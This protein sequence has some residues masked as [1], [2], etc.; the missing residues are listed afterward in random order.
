MGTL[1]K[2]SVLALVLVLM[3]SV[4]PLASGAKPVGNL[5]WL[6][7]SPG[8]SGSGGDQDSARPSISADGRYITFWS[9]ATD[10][11][12]GMVIDTG[13][14]GCGCEGACGCE[15]ECDCELEISNVYLYDVATGETTLVTKGSAGVGC[16][17]A[18]DSPEIS[19]DGS[20]I[21]FRSNATDLIPGE[22]T[23]IDD[24]VFLYDV[25]TQVTTLITPGELGNGLS[26]GGVWGNTI[27]ADGS[28]VAF[29]TSANDVIP[30]KTLNSKYNVFYYDDNTGMTTLVTKGAG[31]LGGDY[32]SVI[33]AISADGTK[34]AFQSRATDLIPSMT[35]THYIN[36]FL[37]D[38]ATEDITLITKGPLGNGCD[39]DGSTGIMNASAISA[40]NTTVVFQSW[41]TDLFDDAALNGNGNIFAYDVATE[42]ITLITAGPLGVGGSRDSHG[43]NISA[44]GSTIG[45][46]SRATDLIADVTTT[47]QQVFTYDV[48]TGTT[49]LVTLGS[50][51]IGGN[52]N[53]NRPSLNADGSLLTF[54]SDATDLMDAGATQLRQVFLVHRGIEFNVTFDAQNDTKPLVVTVAEGSP[55]AQPTD[56]TKAGYVFAGWWTDPTGGVLWDF[57]T[58]I[59]A[60]MTL[61]AHWT[62]AVPPGPD[63]PATGDSALLLS[64][65]IA[66]GFGWIVLMVE[67]KKRR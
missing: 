38:A 5:S 55:V 10:L 51:G 57:S 37:Y 17:G 64:P 36:S 52:A 26:G 34:I 13:S 42:V 16:N 53:S 41:A 21:V 60:D 65:I 63:V 15:G 50:S 43:P 19:A 20:R 40:D 18:S 11:I 46:M 22:P 25:A 23:T 1:R 30:E 58:P 31:G 28:K 14:D 49:S 12:D 54:H 47:G 56:P 61:Y 32:D 39:A 35:T 8:A 24:N 45:F 29:S 67:S 59:T 9:Y 4:I 3:L 33:P 6:L 7:V 66:L 44:D 62:L 48:V 27:N 2:I